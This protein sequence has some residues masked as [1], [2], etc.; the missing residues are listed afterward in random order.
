MCRFGMVLRLP[1]GGAMSRIV[2]DYYNNHANQEWE[3]FDDALCKIEFI[4]TLRLI[5]KYFPK[6]GSVCDIGGGPG[7]YT[8]ELAGKGYQVTLF[9]ISEEAVK[10]A[11]TRLEQ[12]GLQAQ[13]MI[14]GDARDLRTLI[15]GKFDAA[16][17]MGPMYHVIDSAERHQILCQLKDILNPHGVAII[18]YL[19][20]W[21]LIRTG[22]V[23][24]PEW[25]KDIMKLRSML[26]DQVFQGET[27]SNFTEC[28]WSTPEAALREIRSAGLEVISYAGVESFAGGMHPLLEKLSIE[29]P[30]AYAN[31][32]QVAAETCESSQYRDTTDHLHFVVQEH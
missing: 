5:D 25:Y 27:L 8:L 31:V 13:Q 16:L 23:D 30:Q 20:S 14:I 29:N 17:L 32:V 10:L 28:Y 21:G 12:S 15:S 9:D 19:N 2:R 24:F 26:N 7:R 3:R 18:A 4:S 1:A 22:I 6:R 11:R